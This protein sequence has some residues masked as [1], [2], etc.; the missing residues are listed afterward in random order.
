MT[1]PNV[2]IIGWEFPPFNS[3]GLGTACQGL[4][5]ALADLCINQTLVLPK[6]LSVN[7]PYIKLIDPFNPY[8]VQIHVNLE[9][10]PYDTSMTDS[11]KNYLQRKRLHRPYP[12]IIEDAY[13]YSLTLSK[14]SEKCDFNLIHAHDWF[15]YPAGVAVK[16]QSNK[17]LILHVHST[18]FDRTL[19]GDVNPQISA[20]ENSCL[21]QA[22]KIV[23]VSNYT[24]QMVINKY[25]LPESKI[26]VVHNGIDLN[27][28]QYEFMDQEIF[29]WAKGKKLVVFVGRLTV[30]K[31]P[32]YFISIAKKIIAQVPDAL[33]IVAGDGDMFR[34]IV[35][36]SADLNLT[37][38]LLF[39]G[40]LRDRQKA[41][42]YQRA[43]LFIMP[44]VSEPFGIVALEAAK[45]KT[46]VIISKQSG[47][48]EVFPSAFKADFWDIDKIADYAINILTNQ[49]LKLRLIKKG[50]KEIKDISW[51]LAASKCLNIYIQLLN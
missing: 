50:L 20:I 42:L 3:G 30:Q 36:T 4:T 46:P 11:E 10:D 37:S 40:F 21:H 32:D 5:Q 15:T 49:Y 27:S 23:T 13:N 47:V 9:I 6:R 51:E 14:I 43:D 25:N 8:L 38:R 1:L 35:M 17:P 41:L 26:Q 31:G 45:Y 39:A 29:D 33:F 16:K 12:N 19:N 18:E 34:Q 7:P 22:D 44:S 24:K 2:F 48:S 28:E